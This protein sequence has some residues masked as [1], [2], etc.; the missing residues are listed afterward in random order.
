MNRKTLIP[1][2]KQ[3]LPIFGIAS[4]FLLLLLVFVVAVVGLT[5]KWPKP[6][7]LFEYHS[8]IP[9]RYSTKVKVY[10]DVG[11]GLNEQHTYAKIVESSGDWKEI[12]LVLP[13]TVIRRLRLDPAVSPGT[14][15]IRNL[16]VVDGTGAVRL[17][18]PPSAIQPGNQILS[19]SEN[20]GELKVLTTPDANDPFLDIPLDKQIDL[21]LNESP[22]VTVKAKRIVSRVLSVWWAIVLAALLIFD[23]Y[24]KPLFQ[25]K[26]SLLFRLI[27]GDPYQK[28]KMIPIKKHPMDYLA[29]TVILL[30]LVYAAVFTPYVQQEPHIRADGAGYH[31]WTH[32]I[33][34]G[35]F[36]FCAYDNLLNS[37]EL[38][39]SI[40]KL[41]TKCRVKYTP[42]VALIRLPLMIWF[43]DPDNQSG[44]SNAEHQISQLSAI[45]ALMLII[46]VVTKILRYHH[47]GS[48]NIQLAIITVV[49][50]AGL[51]QY[52][53]Y[54]NSYSH[55]FSALGTVLFSLY[56]FGGSYNKQ[57]HRYLFLLLTLSFLFALVRITNVFIVLFFWALWIHRGEIRQNVIR[58]L[59]SGFGIFGAISLQLAYSYYVMGDYSITGYGGMTEESTVPAAYGYFNWDRPMLLSVLF[60]YMNGLVIYFPIF[61]VTILAGFVCRK[62]RTLTLLYLGL[63]LFFALLYGFWMAWHL[64]GSFGHR[65]FVDLSPLSILIL[66]MAFHE[67]RFR[68]RVIFQAL[69]LLCG[70]ITVQLMWGYWQATLTN[71]K[72]GQIYWLHLLGQ[73]GTPIYWH[74]ILILVCVIIFLRNLALSFANS[75]ACR[76]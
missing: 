58:L 36:S 1:S 10:F 6:A 18:V 48:E 28:P 26:T 17:Q 74:S 20:N 8:S 19:L 37:Y 15:G 14:I 40:N 31:I 62:T 54:D 3:P 45:I 53:T 41:G 23:I 67:M 55:I 50:G 32:G 56:T 61:A 70:L 39:T 64:G 46:I 22:E 27:R 4:S 38:I 35:D 9:G 44:F 16:R 69:C 12:R 43:V 13:R 65:G 68:W 72:T 25:R 60:S 47:I 63:I 33:K 75:F 59:A 30:F 42:G 73:E 76:V 21:H 11:E 57:S 24:Y 5:E 52:S 71:P 29:G 34:S 49:F 66:A 2:N 7:L 51:Y